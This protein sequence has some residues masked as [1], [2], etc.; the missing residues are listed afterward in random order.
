S[1]QPGASPRYWLPPSRASPFTR[2]AD[3]GAAPRDCNN[4]DER[5]IGQRNSRRH[6]RGILPAPV[7]RDEKHLVRQWHARLSY[8]EP[9]GE[10][11]YDGDCCRGPGNEAKWKSCDPAENNNQQA[12]DHPSLNDVRAIHLNDAANPTCAMNSDRKDTATA[13]GN[14]ENVAP[15]CRRI[16]RGHGSQ[17][18]REVPANYEWALTTQPFSCPRQ[19]RRAQRQQARRDS[20]GGARRSAS[21]GRQRH[22]RGPGRK[23]PTGWGAGPGEEP[24][25]R[26]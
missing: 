14:L 18:K 24:V 4:D 23:M 26:A 17:E 1:E 7:K 3:R 9:A 6:D 11:D 22:L 12:D 13:R 2:R 8:G 25:G 20:D 5:H 19:Q 15:L 16:L 10:P 21:V